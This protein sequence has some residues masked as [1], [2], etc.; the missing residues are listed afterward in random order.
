MT[1]E[2]ASHKQGH[3]VKWVAGMITLL[4]VY[5]LSMEPMLAWAEK[6]NMGRWAISAVEHLNRPLTRTAQRWPATFDLWLRYRRWSRV[7][8]GLPARPAP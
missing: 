8:V 1:Q 5:A 4:A 6:W 2:N 3:A 7:Q